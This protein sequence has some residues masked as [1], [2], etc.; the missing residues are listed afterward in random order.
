MPKFKILM[1]LVL[2]TI[3]EV[4]GNFIIAIL[5]AIF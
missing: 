2:E 4:I 5:D 3:F 1:E